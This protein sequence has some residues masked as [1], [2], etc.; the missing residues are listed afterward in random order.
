MRQG[1]LRS[2]AA[3]LATTVIW[4]STFVMA[5]DL[6]AIWPPLSYV[7]VRFGLAAAVLI[8]L[9]PALTAKARRREWRSGATLGVLMG[10]GFALQAIGLAYT[11]PTKSAFITGLTT[12]LVLFASLAILKVRPNLENGIGVALASIGGLLI[13][14]PESGVGV[15][16][17]DILTVVATVFF[18]VHITLLSAYA[19]VNDVRQLTVRQILTAA[20]LFSV[21][22]AAMWMVVLYSPGGGL[23]EFVARESAG[24][25]WN[26]QIVWAIAYLSVV[27][28]V[29]TFLLWTWGQARASATHAAVIFSLEPVF[30]AIFAVGLRGTGEWMGRNGTI[31]AA[32]ILLGVLVSELRFSKQRVQ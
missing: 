19:T 2:D 13:L 8:A 21:V 16:V 5:K 7:T 26:A 25:T 12:P 11:T 27:A 4:G 3:L 10:A 32:L 6:L 20:I 17:G 22:C 28:T 14:A 24:L 18:A 29:V 31:G 30:A 15:N 1:A 23:P 9:F